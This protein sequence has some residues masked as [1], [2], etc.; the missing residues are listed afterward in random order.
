M[1]YVLQMAFITIFIGALLVV[2]PWLMPKTECFAVTVPADERE[3]EPLAGFMRAYA[4]RMILCVVVSALAWSIALAAGSFDLSSEQG[5]VAIAVLVAVTTTMPLVISFALMLY[6]RKRVQEVKAER[7]W[8]AAHPQA[9]AYVGPEELPKLPSVAWNLLYIPL[10][11][12]LAAAAV[13]LYD[14][15][16]DM[17]PMRINLNGEV[18]EYVA[19][20]PSSVMFPAAFVA[21]F[22]LIFTACHVGIVHSKKPI[23]PAAPASSA[24]AYGRFA[25][26]Q[27]IALVAGGLLIS[28]ASGVSMLLSSLGTISL[29]AAG[30]IV[31]VATGVFVVAF[32]VASVML[33]QSGA[34]IAAQPTQGDGSDAAGGIARD[35]DKYWLLGVFY[36]NREEPSLFVPKRFGLG[37]TVNLA[38]PATWIALVV[39]TLAIIGFS[40]GITSLLS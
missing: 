20:T 25:Q 6:Y 12:L 35:E 5:Q 10:I 14:Q 31:V 28:T 38:Q 33:G 21:F 40:F 29:G 4:R 3:K 24:L 17:M 2:T 19:K 39:F 1:L 16:P 8:S 36:F 7:G 11:A 26:I 13:M 30:A 15:F 9:A 37:W 27:C 34:R 32:A 18:R 22:G 23:D